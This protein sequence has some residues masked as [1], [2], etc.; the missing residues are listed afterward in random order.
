MAAKTDKKQEITEIPYSDA[1]RELEEIVRKLQSNDCEIDKLRE[2]T[3]RSVELLRICKE[4]L[5]RTDE[6]LK[7][8]LEEID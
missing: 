1:V 5:F 4:K 3:A 6:E 2:Y 7:K 8:L